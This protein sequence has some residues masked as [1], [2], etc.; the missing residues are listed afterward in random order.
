MSELKEKTNNR[1]TNN[2][3]FIIASTAAAVGLGNIWKFPYIMGE[4][5]GGAFVLVYLLCI[6]LIGTP[7]MVAEVMIGRRGR[8]SPGYAAR[9]LA[10][11]SQASSKW[12]GIG[13]LGML[14]CFL[15]LSYYA[16]IAGWATSYAVKSATGTFSGIS[17]AGIG[18]VFASMLGSAPELIFFNSLVIG[19]TVFVVGKGVKQGLEKAVT[20]LMPLLLLLL[21]IVAIYAAKIGD[22]GAAVEFMFKPDF[23]KLTGQGFLIALGHSFFTLGLASGVMIMYGA[24]VPKST[25]IVGTSLWISVADTV[26]AMLAGL[27]IFPIVFG[28]GLTPSEG[29]GLIFQT[30]PFAFSA[31]PSASLIATLFFSMLVLAAFTSVIAM[32]ES[33][34]VFL[35]EKFNWSRWR[36]TCVSGFVLWLLGLGTIFSMTGAGWATWD[37]VILGQELPTI[38]DIVDHIASNILLPLGGLLTS[39]FTGWI[40]KTK[41]SQEE[42]NT[43]TYLY[44]IWKVC[45]RFVA[46]AAILLIFL[47]LLGLVG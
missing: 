18:Q 3:S 33:S 26:V 13:W 15:I 46:P 21:I 9:R 12:E 10:Q 19:S 45:A 17:E 6:F 32:I 2:Y 22:L 37:W 16:V 24:Y 1:W 4:N 41:Y 8:A 27:A 29:P 31:M 38:F 28:Y 5:G 36:A 43:K 44:Y 20:Y 39:V 14:A 7:V 25:S 40:I 47:Q 42:L 11:E 30:L 35:E 34:V 23:S